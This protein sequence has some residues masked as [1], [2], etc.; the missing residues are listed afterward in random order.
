[1]GWYLPGRESPVHRLT[2]MLIPF[3]RIS[4]LPFF[5]GAR[6]FSSA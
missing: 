1:M 3:D 2:T 4:R 5:F 6:W